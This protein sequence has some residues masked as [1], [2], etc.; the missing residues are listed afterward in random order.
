MPK[1]HIPWPLPPDWGIKAKNDK[2]E[3]NIVATEN[4]EKITNKNVELNGSDENNAVEGKCMIYG[5]IGNRP[6]T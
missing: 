1:R 6:Y 3:S 2:E 5:Y 4:P